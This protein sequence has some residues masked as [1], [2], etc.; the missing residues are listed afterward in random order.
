VPDYSPVQGHPASLSARAGAA[1]TGG[2]LVRVVANPL[3]PGMVEPTAAG[4]NAAVAGVAA[5]DAGVDA[6]TGPQAVTV[7]TGAGVIHESIA[8]LAVPIGTLLFAA[9]NGQ[10]TPTAAGATQVGFAVAPSTGTGVA[11]DPFR[12]RWMPARA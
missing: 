2:Q 7:L 11:G 3:V 10:V 8:A 12:V 1:I 9:A 5:H 4:L 6:L